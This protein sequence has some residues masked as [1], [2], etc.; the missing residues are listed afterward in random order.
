MSSNLDVFIHLLR[1]HYDARLKF[2]K[3]DTGDAEDIK[4]SVK[5]ALVSLEPVEI[6]PEL[7]AAMHKE[8][9]EGYKDRIGKPQHF[10]S[11]DEAFGKGITNGMA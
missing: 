8:F 6:S 4:E 1:L 5:K 9:L 11:A 3:K 7:E 2:L 10:Y